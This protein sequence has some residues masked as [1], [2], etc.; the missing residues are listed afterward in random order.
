MP[1]ADTTDAATYVNA[2]K[3]DKGSWFSLTPD[4]QSA[5]LAEATSLI[6]T[7]A[8]KGTKTDPNQ[9]NQFP[10]DGGVSVPTDIKNACIEIAFELGNGQS[11]QDL[12][13]DIG[14]TATQFDRTR[15]QHARRHPAFVHGIPSV[16]AWNILRP[17]FRNTRNIKLVR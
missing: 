16:V 14:I 1:Y 6:D 4:E 11:T 8:F 2:Y 12:G 5:A 13:M 17:Y 3:V 7:L 9:A 10:R 15:A